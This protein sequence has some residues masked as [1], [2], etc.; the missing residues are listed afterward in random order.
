MGIL[1]KIRLFFVKKYALGYL[2][3][4]YRALDGNKT[5]ILIILGVAVWGAARLGYITPDQEQNLYKMFGGAGTMT[6]LA[7]LDKWK[8]LAEDL[9]QE[10]KTTEGGQKP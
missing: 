4:A 7:K 10:I 6:F 2:V 9:A 1:D 5:Q 8:G 3:G